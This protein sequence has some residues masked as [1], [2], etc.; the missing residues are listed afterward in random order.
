MRKLVTILA[1]A[2]YVLVL[3]EGFV[4]IFAPE[5]IVPRY[6]TA[7]DYGVRMNIPG[8][9]YQHFTP[10][11]T[12]EYRINEAGFRAD[13]EYSVQKPADACRV[14]MLG[15]SFMV[16][17]EVELED[18]IPHRVQSLLADAGMDCEVINM[19]VSGFGTAEMLVALEHSGLDYSPDIVVFQ[20]HGTDFQD[21][22][23]ADL[24]R[25]SE[26][27][28][29]QTAD[30]YLPAVNLRKALMMLPLYPFVI[31]HSQLYSALRETAALRV[32]AALA[33]LRAPG[34]SAPEAAE[35]EASAA[36]VPAEATA[37]YAV[38]LAARLLERAKELANANGA[39]FYLLDIPYKTS[40]GGARS[41]LRRFDRQALDGLAVVTTEQALNRHAAEGAQLYYENGHGHF[42]PLG[43]SIVAQEM[44][45]A[46]LRMRRGGTG[47]QQSARSER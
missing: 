27:E 36:D 16:G 18:S 34:K 6:V 15:D 29:H 22:V 20:W 45:S 5:P 17:Y 24:Y 42:T 14:L 10:D 4:R 44:A 28:L 43:Y 23:R 39:Q 8:A 41:T 2:V 9:R 30:A 26:D 3:G 21:N 37:P 25:L 19:G 13:Q 11:A 47:G 31:Q 7:A 12:V 40:T 35:S 46:I 33:Q 1:A 32:K 38:R